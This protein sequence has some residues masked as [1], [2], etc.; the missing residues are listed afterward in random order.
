MKINVYTTQELT[1][2]E[3]LALYEDVKDYEYILNYYEHK[4][5]LTIENGIVKDG[6]TPDDTFRT[7]GLHFIDSE[8]GKSVGLISGVFIDEMMAQSLNETDA[9]D[10]GWLKFAVW[11]NK[12][13]DFSNNTKKSTMFMKYSTLNHRI[14]V[15]DE[16]YGFD[17]LEILEMIWKQLPFIFYKKYG[18]T[19]NTYILEVSSNIQYLKEFFTKKLCKLD[20]N[21][22]FKPI[23]YLNKYE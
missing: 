6:I 3:H 9:D 16:C 15:I 14:F 5:D 4:N 19:I 1:D 22:Y 13:T 8:T 20:K 21:Y 11:Y 17:S 2:K 12:L 18:M 10:K 7:V 23:D